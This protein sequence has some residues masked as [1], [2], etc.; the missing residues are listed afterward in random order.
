MPLE[1]YVTK[2]PLGVPRRSQNWKV[3]DFRWMW[4]TFSQGQMLTKN[5]GS[6]FFL[7]QKFNCDT[8]MYTIASNIRQVSKVH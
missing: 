7:A 8:Q 5:W 2:P 1:V 6:F 4:Q 3:P